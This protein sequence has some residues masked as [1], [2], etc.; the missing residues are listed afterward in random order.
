MFIPTSD[1]KLNRWSLSAEKA[2][3]IFVKSMSLILFGLF[4]IIHCWTQKFSLLV[5]TPDKIRK[6]R[7]RKFK[8]FRLANVQLSRFPSFLYFITNINSDFPSWNPKKTESSNK[9]S[10]KH[11]D[12]LKISRMWRL[13][14]GKILILWKEMQLFDSCL[15]L[16]SCAEI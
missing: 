14:S 7:Q 5:E 13:I 9:S 2:S 15:S 12:I 4:Y 16:I 8:L 6:L 11:I 3:E 10:E 1:D